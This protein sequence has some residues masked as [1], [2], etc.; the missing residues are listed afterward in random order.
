LGRKKVPEALRAGGLDVRVHDDLFPQ[1]TQ[2]V[3]WLREAGAQRWVAITRDDRIRYNQLER[4][5]VL[6]AKLRFFSITSSSLTGD[7]AAAFD[8]VSDPAGLPTVPATTQTGSSRR[9][10]E[11]QTSRSSKRGESSRRP[12]P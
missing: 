1:A 2:D 4:E 6:A 10:R 8:P 12:L 11:G 5:A 3:E 9:S 7:E